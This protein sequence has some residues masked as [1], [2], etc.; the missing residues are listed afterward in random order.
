[1]QQHFA[2]EEKHSQNGEKQAYNLI[3]NDD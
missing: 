2:K 1:M 3:N